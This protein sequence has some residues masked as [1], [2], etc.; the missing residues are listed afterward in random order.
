MN[1]FKTPMILVMVL[2]LVL[3]SLLGSFSPAYAA[4]KGLP[5]DAIVYPHL[6]S[7][8]GKLVIESKL[9]AGDYSAILLAQTKA[10]NADPN[11]KKA[12]ALFKSNHKIAKSLFLTPNEREWDLKDGKYIAKGS[13]ADVSTLAQWMM[14]YSEILASPKPFQGDKAFNAAITKEAKEELI[15]MSQDMIR[16]YIKDGVA[17]SDAAM[18]KTS[19]KDNAMAVIGLSLARNHGDGETKYR[20]DQYLKAAHPNFINAFKQEPSTVDF[21][22]DGKEL[23]LRIEVIGQFLWASSILA[24][25]AIASGDSRTAFQLMDQAERFHDAMLIEG[26]TINQ[27]SPADEV[28]FK[29]GKVQPARKEIAGGNYQRYLYAMNR[30]NA[31][32][33][34]AFTRSTSMNASLSKKWFMTSITHH[35]DKFGIVHDV[36]WANPTVKNTGK[37]TPYQAWFIVNAYEALPGASKADAKVISD[38]LALNQ[39]F[40]FENIKR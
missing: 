20:I 37:E 38:N 13:K 40:L 29:D 31:N 5:A 11:D 22:G 14:V 2:T 30:W 35:S 15:R 24:D 28:L 25:H 18:T 32:P 8:D 10:L 21:T 17:Y 33:Y 34:H 6:V 16:T 19:I 1:S 23:K 27:Y 4:D 26:N 7:F 36:E 3:S 9:T 39:K 12:L